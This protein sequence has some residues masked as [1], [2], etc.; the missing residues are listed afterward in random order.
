MFL[1][2]SENM[3]CVVEGG[4]GL[5]SL[6]IWLFKL[7]SCDCSCV[8]WSLAPSSSFCFCTSSLLVSVK[9]RAKLRICR[10]ILLIRS[11]TLEFESFGLS[12]GSI[13]LSLCSLCRSRCSFPSL[14]SLLNSGCLSRASTVGV[15]GGS[16]LRTF[17]SVLG[18]GISLLFFSCDL[19][20]MGEDFLSS[21]SSLIS[22]SELWS[23][24]LFF[25]CPL[26]SSPSVHFHTFFT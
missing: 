5:L 3:S 1:L 18:L 4:R 26:L 8:T 21:S 7:E 13:C 19:F 17:S 23:L 15:L 14:F 9:S 16:I 11:T 10:S 6:L 2:R 20:L 24:L 12:L 25:L 22:S